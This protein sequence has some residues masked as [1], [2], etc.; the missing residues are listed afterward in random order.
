MK[1]YIIDEN[2]FET[3]GQV[4]DSDYSGYDTPVITKETIMSKAIDVDTS[5]LINYE[6]LSEFNTKLPTEQYLIDSCKHCVDAFALWV[7]CDVSGEVEEHYNT[8][9]L[10]CS[11]KEKRE[12]ASKE[13]KNDS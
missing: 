4:I 7:Q 1:V 5:N 6:K 13:S 8:M 3:V 10:Y 11:Q 9:C 2:D 12:E